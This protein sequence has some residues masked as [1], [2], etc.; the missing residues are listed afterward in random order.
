MRRIK[1]FT[2]SS[3]PTL[4][5]LIVEKLGVSLSPA[6]LK[7]F[8]N[9]EMTIELGV[10]VRN[11]DVFIVQSGPLVADG[12]SSSMAKSSTGSS[13]ESAADVGG[14]INDLLMELLILVNACKSASAKRITAMC[15][16]LCLIIAASI[17]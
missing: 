6:T 16:C 3:H 17:S 15:V 13:K 5:H 8:P 10:S 4:T 12:S 14:S 9:G 1:I 7:T 2:G 11:E